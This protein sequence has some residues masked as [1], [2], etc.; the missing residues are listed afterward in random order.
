MIRWTHLAKRIEGATRTSEK[1]NLLADALRNASDEDLA[2]SC[3]LL[4][5]RG[6]LSPSE[7]L[8]WAS[9]AKAVEEAAGAPAGSLAKLLDEAGDLGTA[10]AELIEA[11]RPL[12]G[13]AL[14]AVEQES[15]ARSDVIA[16]ATGVAPN[17]DAA[18]QLREIPAL[19]AAIAA[20]SGQHRHDLLVQ[21]FYGCSPTATKYLVRLLTGDMRIGLRDGLL[22]TA[23]A[24]A[25]AVDQEEVHW[26]MTLEGDP[27]SVACLARRGALSEAKF[28]PFHPIPAMLAAP[29]ASATEI[30]ER[31]GRSELEK[32]GGTMF[33]ED[34]YDGVRAQLHVA[35][36]RA[37]IYARDL[38]EVTV[39]FPEIADAALASGAEGVFDGEIIATEDGRPLPVAALQSRLDGS[40]RTLGERER[41]PVAFVAFDLLARGS[42]PLMRNTW[43][44]RRAA[45]EAMK[46][47]EQSGGLL[48]I[49]MLQGAR[50]GEE[51]EAAFIAARMRGCEGLV[52]KAQGAPYLPGQRGSSWLKLKRSLDTIDC[53]IVGV[54]PGVGRRRELLSE[55]TIAVRDDLSGRLAPL[56]RVGMGLDDASLAQL[57]QW[58]ELHTVAQLGTYRSVQPSVVVEVSFDAVRRAERSASGFSLKS[59]RIVRVRNDLGPDQVAT[60]SAIEQRYRL[61]HGAQE[62]YD[63]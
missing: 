40:A 42:E 18:P 3:Q 48:Q 59:A 32:S 34:K 33:V 6:P 10:A 38:R 5:R 24:T 55:C 21:T 63:A 51:V 13:A 16:Q 47:G 57:S 45:L 58:F 12:A 1:V 36:G 23:I 60:L 49:A 27:G 14:A 7:P 43:S 20:A 8:S 22:E 31:M 11:E 61:G 44:D 2:I 25:F 15:Q 26:A 35:G 46:L 54:E 53:V 52:A 37:E 28:K 39:S 30:V 62:H 17:L 9:I 56:G 50:S 4:A 19:L 29:V 41:I